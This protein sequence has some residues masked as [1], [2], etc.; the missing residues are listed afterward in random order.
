M[1]YQNALR[2]DTH[3]DN[4]HADIGS[5]HPVIVFSSITQFI[6]ILVTLSTVYF[7]ATNWVNVVRQSGL[8]N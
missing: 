6:V 1:K 5:S 8:N 3:L 2:F 4:Y 7:T